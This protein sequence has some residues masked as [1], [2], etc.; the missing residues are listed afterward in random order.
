MVELRQPALAD[1]AAY[2]AALERGWSSSNL[3]NTTQAELAEIARDSA[4]FV[5]RL[6]GAGPVEP[7]RK[8]VRWV[9]AAGEFVGVVR[10]RFNAD[11]S[12]LAP[13]LPGHLGYSIVPW[14]RG[15]GHATAA[16]GAMLPVAK[17]LGLQEL[18]AVTLP[19]N[20]ASAAVLR[21]NGAVC[22]GE[23]PAADGQGRWVWWRI[24]LT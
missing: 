5:A 16:L 11:M 6:G 8:V 14:Q 23:K 18:T 1:V 12:P 17:E 10:F 21:K 9:F 24:A 22:L 15:R 13:E 19:E 20:G 4:A 7:V 3:A 2:A